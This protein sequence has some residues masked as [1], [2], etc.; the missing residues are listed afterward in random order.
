MKDDMQRSNERQG[1]L[2]DSIQ[3]AETIQV[4]NASW[5]F[6]E[7]W[8]SISETVADRITNKYSLGSDQH[9]IRGVFIDTKSAF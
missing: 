8:Q 2:V 7:I 3:G 1:L 6:S 9:K 4:A 5:H